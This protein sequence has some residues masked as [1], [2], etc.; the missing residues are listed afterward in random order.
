MEKD[1][2]LEAIYSSALK[3]NQWLETLEIINK[4]LES[5]HIF[6]AERSSISESPISFVESGFERG[7][8]ESYQQHFFA[9]D[10]WSHA[11]IHKK[12][13]EFHASHKV[14]DD[15]LFEQSEIYQDFARP[16]GIRN[17]IGCLFTDH[18][19][20]IHAEIG[21]MRDASRGRYS[22]VDVNR[23]NSLI[24]H[25]NNALELS[26]EYR[27]INVQ[28]SELSAILDHS[29]DALALFTLEGKILYHNAPWEQWLAKTRIAKS[30]NKSL[31]W[32]TPSLQNQFIQTLN[33][34]KNGDSQSVNFFIQDAG[35]LLNLQIKPTRHEF[36]SAIGH[37]SIE[38]ALV[39]IISCGN[40]NGPDLTA[41]KMMYRM[42]Q[43][44]A[45]VAAL[46]CK[47]QNAE[48]IAHYRGSSIGTIRQQIKSCLHKTASSNQTMMMTK[49][50][51]LIYY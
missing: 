18:S 26:K 28:V 19:S 32:H 10:L 21:V 50:F 14:V 45:E 8:F 49:L 22:D 5:S 1:S 36:V 13:N 15:R 47:G 12:H 30:S 9:V 4:Y 27:R 24:P 31:Y 16:A 6:I 37:H 42:T 43:A 40:E 34:Y 3:P 39:S 2:V 35:K 7:H 17:G 25:I 38:A 46:L 33:K 29:R 23:A 20:G 44:E 11:L 48:E 41:M 51:R